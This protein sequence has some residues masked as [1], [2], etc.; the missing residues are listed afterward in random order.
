M[1]ST[2]G[3]GL[4]ESER[5]IRL[6]RP[7]MH[8]RANDNVSEDRGGA[9]HLICRASRE[10]TPGGDV[11]LCLG[12]ACRVCI[13]IRPGHGFRSGH[14]GVAQILFTKLNEPGRGNLP[15]TRRDW[16]V[17]GASQPGGSLT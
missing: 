13:F 5:V 16:Y 3:G 14:L 12:R 8:Q 6:S 7:V 4:C 11:R 17:E 9:L 10:G 1:K 2:I 15:L